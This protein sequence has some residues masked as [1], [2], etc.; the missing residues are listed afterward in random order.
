MP[1]RLARG[2][3]SSPRTKRFFVLIASCPLQNI[4]VNENS[5]FRIGIIDVVIYI[6]SGHPQHI[7]QLPEFYHRCVQQ[8]RQMDGW[9]F[10]LRG[11]PRHARWSCGKFLQ[12]HGPFRSDVS[13]DKV[14][15]RRQLTLPGD[16]LC[17]FGSGVWLP[18][19]QVRGIY[20]Q[21]TFR[22][23]LTV[24]APGD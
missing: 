15:H 9:E 12:R 17:R 7:Q 11:S 13:A 20:L 1:N 3:I 5:E 18:E 8:R 23:H 14:P 22:T 19:L 10:V 2:A 24:S 4:G 6:I 21:Y 16:A